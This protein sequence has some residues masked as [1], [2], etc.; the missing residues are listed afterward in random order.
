MKKKKLQ[1][2]LIVI[3]FC[4]VLCTTTYKTQKKDLVEKCLNQSIIFE[5]DKL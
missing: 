1:K 5:L 4:V 3:I 2:I